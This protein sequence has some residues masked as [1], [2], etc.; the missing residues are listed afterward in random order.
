LLAGRQARRLSH[1]RLAER[2]GVLPS[3]V[4]RYET[5]TLRP[6]T[7]RLHVYAAVLDL[8]LEDLWVLAGYMPSAA[9]R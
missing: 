6:S 5:G 4:F 2:L 9:Q 3:S 8:D 1:Q 7:E